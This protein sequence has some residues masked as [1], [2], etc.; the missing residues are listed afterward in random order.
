M[1]ILPSTLAVLLVLSS[2]A[3]SDSAAYAQKRSKDTMSGY[4]R[5]ARATV[6]HPAIV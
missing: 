5:S 1:R 2:I 4:D 6:V 3:A